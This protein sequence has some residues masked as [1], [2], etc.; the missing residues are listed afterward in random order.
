VLFVDIRNSVKLNEKHQTQTMGRIYTA[1][2]KAIL[3]IAY[4]HNGFVRNIIGDRVMIVFSSG[5]LFY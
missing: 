2:T 5:K 3:K 1:F 4:H